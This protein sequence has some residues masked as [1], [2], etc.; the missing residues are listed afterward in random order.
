MSTL[1]GRVLLLGPLPPPV[2]GAAVVTQTMLRWL[3]DRGTEVTVVDASVDSHGIA[4]FTSRSAAAGYLIARLW[5][6]LVCCLRLIRRPDALYIGGAG[7]SGLLFQLL[8]IAVARALGVPVVFHHHSS[9]YL[10]RHSRPMA[11]ICRLTGSRS[12][13]LALSRSMA[14]QLS[15]QYCSHAGGPQVVALSNAIFVAP[16]G[17]LPPRVP[18]GPIRLGHI[19]VLSLDK[20]LQE[21]VDTALA[22]ASEDVS[23]ELHVAGAAADERSQETVD[24][25]LAPLASDRRVTVH[26]PVYGEALREF[27]AGLDLLLFPSRYRNEAAPMVVLEAA[28]YGVPTLAYPSGSLAELVHAEVLLVPFGDFVP[29][30][31]QLAREWHQR[32]AELSAVTLD[33]FQNAREAS[34]EQ[35]ERLWAGYLPAGSG[36]GE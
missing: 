17:P 34:S 29:R 31:V 26:G 36:T 15:A 9:A 10:N 32:G 24:R 7:G 13:H 20:G 18:G 30:A 22:L 1:T 25:L 12:T 3:R 2:H 27:Y 11:L 23:F 6:H 28:S 33:G 8:P 21:V 19:S 14:D 5:H 35:R 4:S 16:V